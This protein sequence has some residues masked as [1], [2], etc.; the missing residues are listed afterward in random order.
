MV[1][2]IGGLKYIVVLKLVYYGIYL[3]CIQTY[4]K[5][6]HD[7]IIVHVQQFLYFLN[8]LLHGTTWK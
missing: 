2:I 6:Y 8:I 1:N 4:F 5:K 3:L 7:S